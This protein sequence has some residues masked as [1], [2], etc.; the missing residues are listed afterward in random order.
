MTSDSTLPPRPAV[1]LWGLL[2]SG[3]LIGCLAT[4]AGLLARFHWVLELTSHFA[5]QLAVALSVLA[6]GCALGRRWVTTGVIAAFALINIGLVIQAARPS[7]CEA[8]V[9]DASVR[10]L[11]LNVHTAN[12]RS[13][14]VA[15]AIRRADADVVLLMEVNSRWLTEL[16]SLQT[17]YPTLIAQ[18]REDNF[19]I[20]LLTRLPVSHSEI[21]AFSEAGVPSIIADLTISN[22]TLRLLGTHPVPPGS[23]EYSRLRN[24][25]LEATTD[26]CRQQTSPLAILGDLN[27]TPWSPYF[28]ILEDGGQLKNARPTWGLDRTWPAGSQLFGIPLDHCLVSPELAVVRREV[29]GDVGSDHLPLLVELTVLAPASL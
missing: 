2:E 17:N 27:V 4:A 24:E 25:Q 13:D 22:R 19:G 18:P 7:R 1:T 28:H 6:A 16:A 29:G 3:G 9:A 10:L 8:T 23:A 14:L 12:R 15:E 5:L 21:I 20:A 11:S 26:W